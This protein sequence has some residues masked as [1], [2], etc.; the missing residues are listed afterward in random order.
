MSS[1]MCREGLQRTM[2]G[3]KLLLFVCKYVGMFAKKLIVTCQL[4]CRRVIRRVGTL[5]GRGY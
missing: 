5:L 1:G 2:M 3:H 4:I